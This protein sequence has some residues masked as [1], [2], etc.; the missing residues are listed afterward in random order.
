MGR[1][2]TPGC[3]CCPGA[4]AATTAVVVYGC[5]QGVG[6]GDLG[7]V[8][9]ASVTL[10]G[11]GYSGTATTDSTGTATLSPRP[12]PGTYTLAVTP[13]STRHASYS[14]IIT[15]TT[16]P[17]RL[18][19]YL[20]PASCYV[21]VLESGSNTGLA[22]GPGAGPWA[23]ALTLTTHGGATA[24]L[25]AKD[26]SL[27]PAG[28]NDPAFHWQ[29]QDAAANTYNLVMYGQPD[30]LGRNALLTIFQAVGVPPTGSGFGQ[31]YA[32]TG[33]GPPLALSFTVDQT[34][35]AY[36]TFATTDEPY[37]VAEATNP[38]PPSGTSATVHVTGCNGMALANATVTA[39][40]SGYAN[41]SGTT[42]SSG[43]V[44]LALPAGGTWSL[45]ASKTGFA[46]GSSSVTPPAGTVTIALTVASGYVCTTF[47]AD[48][49]PTT[50]H[51]THPLTGSGT[52]VA[53]AYDAA[54][55]WYTGCAGLTGRVGAMPDI[56]GACL[57]ASVSPPVQF[58][59]D[60][61]S[62]NPGTLTAYTATCP[63][64]TCPTSAA[65]SRPTGGWTSE[66]SAAATGASETCP[67]APAFSWTGT[68]T[69]PSGGSCNGAIFNAGSISIS[70]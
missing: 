46:T 16:A 3:T 10:T 40:Q 32:T 18:A 8:A 69:L 43:N 24:T 44:T 51:L 60:P 52:P 21:C 58:Y 55:H 70:I 61:F 29:G 1:K 66:T 6:G 41:V 11:T 64:G 50:L 20:S 5:P 57:T 38:C 7:V 28:P 17:A 25:L 2:N 13:P 22:P 42:D 27:L 9:G 49:L 12:G 19:A 23:Q 56:H 31:A 53:I 26:Q 67:A 14:A 45:S 4:P 34:G 48:P 39:S 37:T 62:S 33:F 30:G 68:L 59:F 63:G 36:P 54:N 65:C 15:A 47:C 35:G